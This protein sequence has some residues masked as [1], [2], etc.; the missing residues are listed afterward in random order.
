M[1]RP[2]RGPQARPTGTTSTVLSDPSS[3]AA[4]ESADSEQPTP[5]ATVHEE[6]VV[7][8]VETTLGPELPEPVAAP[9]EPAPPPVGAT[10]EEEPPSEPTPAQEWQMPLKGATL[11]CDNFAEIG[12]GVAVQGTVLE[13]K[14]D[15]GHVLLWLEAAKRRWPIHARDIRGSTWTHRGEDYPAP[16]TD[17]KFD[18]KFRAVV[19]NATALLTAPAAPAKPALPRPARPGH[20]W[21][22]VA[23]D[24]VAALG[25]DT[26]G[27]RR[28]DWKMGETAE[29]TIPA[30]NG[31]PAC[32]TR[33]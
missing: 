4:A 9:P 8:I 7:P 13:L 26:S 2:N 14:P 5:G 29:L 25:F 27:T 11:R 3:I 15:A 18:R 19:A 24:G 22:K 20:V 30:V 31:S 1:A 21:V 28:R 16:G 17:E 6:P 32:F 23:V 12:N 10:F 33:L